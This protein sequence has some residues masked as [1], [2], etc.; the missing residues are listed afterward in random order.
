MRHSLVEK[1]TSQ[2]I[3]TAISWW[4]HFS[5]ANKVWRDFAT[6]KSAATSQKRA[7][8]DFV[9]N[10]ICHYF[11]GKKF[12]VTSRKGTS[13]DFMTSCPSCKWMKLWNHVLIHH[14]CLT[15]VCIWRNGINGIGMVSIVTFDF[16]CFLLRCKNYITNIFFFMQ[17]WA[18]AFKEEFI[19][20]YQRPKSRRVGCIAKS[21]S[22]YFQTQ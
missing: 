8:R 13:C 9:A 10:E 5:H 3:F 2:W 22:R 17:G 6:K 12:I 16:D 1:K 15:E 14:A 18:T 20:S 21:Q 11:A 4:L 7:S 19:S